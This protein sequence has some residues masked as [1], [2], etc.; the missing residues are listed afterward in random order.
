M[1]KLVTIIAAV[2]FSS[3]VHAA[4]TLT[5][6]NANSW[7]YSLVSGTT[8]GN[9]VNLN[10]TDGYNSGI[11][12]GAA[13]LLINTVNVFGNG[14]LGVSVN[15]S[16]QISYGNSGA[17]LLDSGTIVSASVG[18][19]AAVSASQNSSYLALVVY[20]TATHMYGISAGELLS[21]GGTVVNAPPST[22]TL[23]DFQN[24]YGVN[25]AVPSDPANYLVADT[26]AIPEPATMALF[27]IGAGVLA[28]RRRFQKKA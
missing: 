6:G 10:G 25:P 3:A 23:T 8:V 24:N 18:G 7:S 17:T 9:A 19:N 27:G 4:A 28:L 22:T 1:K 26:Q 2:V 11:A 21:S 14:G 5:W 13:W 12:S 15:S 16:G 20:D